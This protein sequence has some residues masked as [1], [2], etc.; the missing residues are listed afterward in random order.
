MNLLPEK[1]PYINPFLDSKIN[2]LGDFI[3]TSQVGRE[4]KI[5]VSLTCKSADLDIL[6]KTIYSI[7]NQKLKADKIILWL[8]KNDYT[9]LNLPYYITRFVKNGL[10]IRFIEDLGEYNKTYYPMKECKNFIIVTANNGIYYQKDWLQKLYLSYISHPRDIHVHNIKKVKIEKNNIVLKKTD[11]DELSSFCNYAI[12]GILYPPNCFSNEILRKDIFLKYLAKNSNTWFWL[13]SLAHNR[14]I[15]QVKNHNHFI[16][17][18]TFNEFLNKK[19]NQTI[20]PKEIFNFYGA[21]I[22]NKIKNCN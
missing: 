10:E 7:L 17:T 4:V 12:S 1:I 16:F 20:L 14:K 19:C 11:N 9:M 21:N 2:N 15:R 22:E 13:M 5:L 3:G 18:T 6:P 8:D